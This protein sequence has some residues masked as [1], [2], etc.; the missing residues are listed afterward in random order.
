MI[1]SIISALWRVTQE[2]CHESKG[3]LAYIER[4]R[5]AGGGSS[6]SNQE[7]LN[8]ISREA[9]MCFRAVEIELRPILSDFRKIQSLPSNYIAVLEIQT[10]WIQAWLSIRD[11]LT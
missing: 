9:I 3:R 1:C 8:E 10:L 6:K 4:P 2:D 7:T 11:C 5:R